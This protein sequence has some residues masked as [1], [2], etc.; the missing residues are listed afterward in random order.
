[1]FK[2]T[3]K[4]RKW[5]ILVAMS[6]TIS[7]IFIDITVLPVAL[8]TIQR[9]LNFS[10]LTLQWIVN[11]YTLTL[12]I[13]VLAGGRLSD[14]FGAKKIFCYGVS[15][16]ALASAFCG[17][18]NTEF[19]FIASRVLQGIGGAL[20]IP[21]TSLI[22]FSSFPANERGKAFGIFISIGSIFLSLG[23]FI[24]GVLTEYVNWRYVFWINLPIAAFGYLLALYSVPKSA[25][26]KEEF[27]YFGFFTITTGICALVIGIMQSKHWGWGSPLTLSLI[28]AGLILIFLLAL[29]ERSVTDPFIDFKL[30]KNRNFVGSVFSTFCTQFIVMVTVFWAIYFQTALTFTP[31]EAGILALLANIPVMIA[32]PIGGYLLDRFGPK[33]PMTIGYVLLVGSLLWFSQVLNVKSMSTLLTAIIPFGCAIPLIFS[34]SFNAAMHEA[35]DSKRGMVSGLISAIRQ[36]GATL[37]MAIFGALFLNSQSNQFS[38]ALAQNPD[39]QNLKS[40]QFEGLLAQAPQAV[41]A[42]K[43]LPLSIQEYIKSSD[44]AAYIAAFY[45]INLLTI[46][47]AVLGLIVTLFCIRKKPLTRK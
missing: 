40:S 27:D 42:L 19:S 24:G 25:T 13:L 21:S 8:P 39:T 33:L 36:F 18:S 11:C 30:F 14:I 38:K 7:M 43:D 34:P 32:A 28:V 6:S 23:P 47:M 37:G 2:L 46:F 20:L 10:D 44:L 26:K 35:A 31:V 41:Q 4:N 9:L 12:A 15:L 16:F 22:I 45:N 3:E 17:L 1:M 5:W 29:F